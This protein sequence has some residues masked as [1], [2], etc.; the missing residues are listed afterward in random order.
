MAKVTV[1]P[2]TL[3]RI[4]AA[5]K[6][7][8]VT[9]SSLQR[10]F[11]PDQI[12]AIAGAFAVTSAG[13]SDYL[14][15]AQAKLAQSIAN[16]NNSNA[17]V[18][19][20]LAAT[21]K[22]P[23]SKK[24][25]KSFVDRVGQ[26]VSFPLTAVTSSAARFFD[27]KRNF[28]KD[29]TSGVTP[30][31]IFA[32]QEWYKGLDP[33]TKIAV[34]L[35]TSIA[36][37]PLTYLA[38]AGVISK[39]GGAAGISKLAETAA[40]GAR[41]A[42]EVEDAARLSNIAGNLIRKG[43]GG[44][45]ALDKA[46]M[47]WLSG[48]LE[49]AN[50]IDQ[51]L[52]GGLYWNVPGTGRVAGRIAN[53]AGAEA[54][55]LKQIYLGRPD[56]MRKVSSTASNTLGRVKTAK[57]MSEFGDRYGG[58]EGQ[59]KRAILK[60]ESPQQALAY[61]NIQDASRFATGGEATYGLARSRGLSDIE[62][63]LLNQKIDPVDLNNAMGGNPEAVA[64][65]SAVDPTLVDDAK[66]FE[67]SWKPVS[68]EIGGRQLDAAGIGAD[69]MMPIYGEDVAMH[70]ASK[71]TDEAIEAGVGQ[72]KNYKNTGKGRTAGPDL[73]RNYDVGRKFLNN[74]LRHPT[75][76][77]TRII[78]QDGN[79]I[80]VGVGRGRAGREAAMRDAQYEVLTNN[81]NVPEP[82]A[83]YRVVDKKGRVKYKTAPEGS[84]R[85]QTLAP[86]KAGR[87][88]REQ[89]NALNKAAFGYELFDLNYISNQRRALRMYT[90][91]HGE[92]VAAAY[93]RSRP[94]GNAELDT[95]LKDYPKAPKAARARIEKSADRLMSAIGRSEEAYLSGIMVRSEARTAIRELNDRLVKAMDEIRVAAGKVPKNSPKQTELRAA[96]TQLQNEHGLL[97]AKV[98]S[99]TERVAAG[100]IKSAELESELSK[101]VAKAGGEPG[102][103]T[104]AAGA[105]AA[106]TTPA[107]A[108]G[109]APAAPTA[110]V[111]VDRQLSMLSSD[112]ADLTVEVDDLRNAVRMGQG[113]DAAKAELAAAEGRLAQAEQALSDYQANAVPAGAVPEPTPAPAGAVPEPTVPAQPQQ[114]P[115]DLLANPENMQGLGRFS[116]EEVRSAIQSRNELE[117]SIA[118]GKRDIESARA[119]RRGAAAA[120]KGVQ[121]EGPKVPKLRQKVAAAAERLRNAAQAG[122]S[123]AVQKAGKQLDDARAAVRQAEAD[124]AESVAT[125]IDSASGD[126]AAITKMVDK[127]AADEA[128][129]AQLRQDRPFLNK[130]FT[131]TEPETVTFQQGAATYESVMSG[132]PP[133]RQARI[134]E[135]QQSY[136]LRPED[137]PEVV[138]RQDAYETAKN[139]HQTLLDLGASPEQ[140]AVAEWQMR[141]ALRDMQ[142]AETKRF[143][144]YYDN[145]R[146][147]DAAN[148]VAVDPRLGAAGRSWTAEPPKGGYSPE[149]QASTAQ[150]V[151]DTHLMRGS[152]EDAVNQ[153]TV[154][155]RRARNQARN[156]ELKGGTPKGDWRAM[157]NELEGLAQTEKV[158]ADLDVRA[159]DAATAAMEEQVAFGNMTR[160]L[161]EAQAKAATYPK[162]FAPDP[163][164]DP[165]F[166][167]YKRLYEDAQVKTIQA[168]K[169]SEDTAVVAR[170]AATTDGLGE[171]QVMRL[172]NSIDNGNSHDVISQVTRELGMEPT[173]RQTMAGVA[174]AVGD[175]PAAMKAASAVVDD[176][177][178]V[179]NVVKSS[180]TKQAA[181]KA[182]GGEPGAV[183]V[184][185]KAQRA[186]VKTRERINELRAE[187]A[188]TAKSTKRLTTEQAN[189]LAQLDEIESNIKGFAQRI[190]RIEKQK[191]AV[192]ANNL[193]RKISEMNDV[194]RL[195]LDELNR[196][197]RAMEIAMAAEE[198]ALTRLGKASD[199]YEYAVWLHGPQADEA[200]RYIVRKGFAEISRSSQ[201]PMDIAD[202]MAL[203]TKITTPKELPSF[204]KY[205]DRATRLFK[206]WAVATP[207]FIARNGY[208]GVFM[209]YLFDVSPGATQR[210][211]SADRAFNQAIKAGQSVEQALEGLPDT[212]RMVHASGVL[213]QGGQVENVLAD[214]KQV[215][216]VGRKRDSLTFLADTPLNRATYNMNAQ[217]ERVLRGAAA[218]HAAETGRGLEGIYDLVFKAHFNYN[219]LNNFENA[220]M[221]RISPFYTWFRKNLPTQMEMVFRNPKAYAR[222]V[223]AKDSIEAAS[224]PEDLIPAWMTDRMN[225]RL[226]FAL[227]GGQT[228]LMPDMP[229]KDLNVLGNWNDLLGQV[230]PV[231]KT[232]IE[233]M[234]DTKLYFGES[235][236]FLG[237]VQVPDTYEKAGLGSAME[238][239]GF[240]RRDSNGNLMAR[241]KHLYAMEQFFPLLGRARRLL[242]DEPRYQDRLP[243]TV[244]NT[245][246]GLSL[247]ANTE[248]DKYGEV[249]ARQKKID[250]MAEDLQKLGYG[251]Y[252][253][254]QKQVAL[255]SKP[256]PT[257][258]RPYLTLLQPKG[259]L[260]AD[261]PF[262][263]VAS[264]KK[265]IDFAA[266]AASIKG[267]QQ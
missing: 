162:G 108:A 186:A 1:S 7:R 155:M 2:E 158:I 189:K 19:S 248:A 106:A 259:G 214:L 31:D 237:Y 216:G 90:A 163:N 210:F 18:S 185:Q 201:S 229:I 142:T 63:R 119:A 193:N 81:R 124:W 212:Y 40:I 38:G 89:V 77:I 116:E 197:Q 58:G 96:L 78:D 191:Q 72:G 113:G 107:A 246:F 221:K 112:V 236:P 176:P 213:E 32:T 127:V 184:S 262:T 6:A 75:E 154:K 131:G 98:E 115:A 203:V 240:A 47:G 215:T 30:P 67:K 150:Y 45:G 260:P 242:P 224:D 22:A 179:T 123:A 114:S 265:K 117:A 133:E 26:V 20:K 97:M 234:M 159:A 42:G 222:Y 165:Q 66:A 183:K 28:L 243:V 180:K 137:V 188:K 120:R 129:L 49:K 264:T 46:E 121:G 266:L 16:I 205:F 263:N 65:V 43:Q 207:G 200:A 56:W 54:P 146:A 140:V 194:A 161:D 153:K 82:T 148:R 55:E 85:F 87:S 59:I 83:R 103:A 267:S 111:A 48:Q 100:Q 41:T 105:G 135:L 34:G 92:E 233:L 93:L 218:M 181:A 64:R 110:G 209:N 172:V 251:G 152:L 15:N 167:E 128:A 86:D 37:D 187:I 76:S 147:Q 99:L 223:E 257:D 102:A 198:K 94:V 109:A 235:A 199:D 141:G 143:W 125:K 231:I 164:V 39:A 241:D 95:I 44:L 53:L 35:G 118:A 51:P 171:E 36:L 196:G 254:W 62:Q 178:A 149:W 192:Y 17:P 219:D 126:T 252:D 145:L 249:K 50:L 69:Q 91:A 74:D 84:L 73:R 29:L 238:M 14:A 12:K 139:A 88:V 166:L 25:T 170:F 261:S 13:S 8:P 169:L 61:R 244:L 80:G 11:T 156:T 33:V 232:P 190:D 130:G 258:K 104:Q 21:S 5:N 134:T 68:M 206:S 160:A 4:G 204:F 250:Q 136:R 227:P 57:I 226:P 23:G 239:L 3:A 228:Y 217:M 52:R 173:Q 24:E 255:A 101:L 245:L 168:S 79:V 256:S 208:S 174:K 211:L 247:R 138:A 177:A 182:M 230:N 220:V 60:A 225:I 195:R 132:L 253:Y 10:T 122:D 27:P 157:N 9:A 202:A 175:D 151:E 70:Q 144:E 71:L